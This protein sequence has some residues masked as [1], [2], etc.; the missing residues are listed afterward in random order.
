MQ[1]LAHRGYWNKEIPANSEQ[2]LYAALSHG[3]GFESDLRDY[4]K[5]LVI[6]HNM[7]DRDSPRADRIFSALELQKNRFCFAINI[8]ADGLIDALQDLLLRYHIT[9]YFTFDMS[10]PQMIEYREAGLT[11]FSRQS[12]YEERPHLYEDA[13]GVWIDAFVEEGWITPKLVEQHLSARKRVCLVSPDLHR[14][15][16]L[17]FWSKLR[18]CFPN[19]DMLMLC[20]DHPD[21]A[22]RYFCTE[23]GISHE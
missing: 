8:K 6:S 16:Y 12:E 14:R 10:L 22:R 5:R 7:A 4:Q 2:A 19:T 20:T 3:Y 21:E 1:I 15:P 11:Y 13:A 17:A 9:N 23:G 18:D